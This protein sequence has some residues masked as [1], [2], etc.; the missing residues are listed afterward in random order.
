MISNWNGKVSEKYE[1]D[2]FP[3]S[4]PEFLL[5][6]LSEIDS[7][8]NTSLSQTHP[9][10]KFRHVPFLYYLVDYPLLLWSFLVR[11][12]F[13]TRRDTV[14]SPPRG[15]W[16]SF[17]S[18]ALL[19]VFVQNRM[20]FYLFRQTELVKQYEE[21]HPGRRTLS[22]WVDYLSVVS[23]GPPFTLRRKN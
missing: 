12:T 16:D 19:P 23:L 15:M 17:L 5:H 4:L 8:L 13:R 21:R 11:S 9:T 22:E 3:F 7:P 14:S 10:R 6:K 1:K 20:I 2:I 18:R